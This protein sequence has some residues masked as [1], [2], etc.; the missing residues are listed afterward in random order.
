MGL[1]S[2]SNQAD[3][4][5]VA[6]FVGQT[7]S[8]TKYVV[9]AIETN[10]P[11]IRAALR[12]G[13]LISALSWTNHV[14]HVAVITNQRVFTVRKGA[15]EKSLDFDA[16]RILEHGEHNGNMMVRVIP[17]SFYLDFTPSDKMRFSV[18]IT[19]SCPTP[20]AANEILAMIGPYIGNAD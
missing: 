13:E 16:I 18:T 12:A 6:F 1:F 9:K 3:P 19:M 4:E 7:G 15:L 17:H 2:G 5:L 8:P 11:C 14:D 10:G 20:R